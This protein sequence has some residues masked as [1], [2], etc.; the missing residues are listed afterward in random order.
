MKGLLALVLILASSPLHADPFA[1][2]M[3]NVREGRH[4][5]A[6]AGFHDLAR[7]GDAT[8]AHNLAILFALGQGVPQNRTEAAFWA[9]TALLAGLERAVPLADL[10][11][12]DLSSADRDALSARLEVQFAPLSAKGDGQAMLAL[13]VVLALVRAEPDLL[14]AH[15]WQ[16]IAAALD[17][18]GAARARELTLSM[19][20]PAQRAQAQGQAWQAFADWCRAQELPAPPSCTVIET[21]DLRQQIK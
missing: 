5:A 18:L 15:A 12:S 21:A 8:A 14:A 6:V 1:T 10:M 7:G 4:A 16:S 11:L 3:Q 19:M 2:A 13:A 9:V 20:T 17:V